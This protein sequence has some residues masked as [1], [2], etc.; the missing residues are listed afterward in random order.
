MLGLPSTTECN[1]RITKQK[2]YENL[3]VTPALKQL[4]I[5][6]IDSVYWTNKLSAETINAS[7]GKYVDEIEVFHV[8]LTSKDIDEKVLQ[9]I[10]KGIPYQILY[11]L[12]HDKKY[13][14][15]IAYKQQSKVVQYFYLDWNNIEPTVKLMGLNLDDIYENF[16]RLIAR[17]KLTD[18][19]LD[20]AVLK[21]QY[22]LKAEKEI[23]RLEKLARKE[24]QPKKKF[25]YVQE[26]NNLKEKYNA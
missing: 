16:I 20:E 7:E 9:Q 5:K 25:E 10:D 1:M 19:S 3:N 8:K 12:E 11:V 4:F 17:G 22:K 21:Y 24:V 26:I 14:L 15:C 18:V 13:K 6:Q 2:F 23:E